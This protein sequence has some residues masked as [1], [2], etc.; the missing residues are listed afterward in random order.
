MSVALDPRETWGPLGVWKSGVVEVG[1]GHPLGDGAG[2]GGG[3][4]CRT[5]GEWTMGGI[6]SEL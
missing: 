2:Q 5:V 4:R 1:V 3:V 6:K